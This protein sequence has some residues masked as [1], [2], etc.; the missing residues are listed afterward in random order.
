MTSA[1]SFRPLPEGARKP[2]PDLRGTED[3][4]RDV[5]GGIRQG[6]RHRTGR[7]GLLA[8][9]LEALESLLQVKFGAEG[10]TLLPAFRS[11]SDPEFLRVVVQSVKQ[12]T[13]LDEVR[14]LLPAPASE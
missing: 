9:R 12:A 3:A 10:E 8:G 2:H 5:R 4:V 7:K 14:K 6:E 11:I 13:T 1:N